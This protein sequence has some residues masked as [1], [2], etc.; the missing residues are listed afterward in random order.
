MTTV[1]LEAKGISKRYPMVSRRNARLRALLSLLRG[2]EDG[3][4]TQVLQAMDLTVRRGE[5]VGIVGENGAGKSTLL[6]IITG[7]LTP[8]TGTLTRQGT[9]GALL[10]LGAGFH[11]EYSG[12]ENLRM[13]AALAGLSAGEIRERLPQIV[14]FADIGHYIDE[15]VKHYS[16]GMVVRLG[17]A[18][19]A[20]LKPDLLITDEVLAVGDESFQKK[21]IRWIERYLGDGGTLL[22]VSHGMYHVQKLCRTALWLRQGQVAEH[23]DAFAVTQAYLAY[24]ERKSRA[25]DSA[26]SDHGVSEYRIERWSLDGDEDCRHYVLDGSDRRIAIEVL[27]RTHEDS[28]PALLFGIAQASGLP[29]Y[30]VSSEID[31][32]P[33]ERVSP[34]LYRYRLE[35]DLSALLPGEFLLRLHPMDGEGMRLFGTSEIVLTVRGSTRELGAVRLPHR[36]LSS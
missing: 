14:D 30:G 27:I 22:M 36:W 31:R 16:S 19:V 5:S 17:F 32:Q 29:V 7:V 3:S 33:A 20:S 18:I 12:R 4:G 1:L 24:H 8:S 6:K 2:R 26:G 34:G 21:C 10:E 28:A 15:P 13:S 9:V 35:L 25:H 23:G 11:A